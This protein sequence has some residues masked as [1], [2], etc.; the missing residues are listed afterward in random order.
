MVPAVVTGIVVVIL[1]CGFGLGFIRSIKSGR[2]PKADALQ[3]SLK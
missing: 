3:R 1:L 2:Q